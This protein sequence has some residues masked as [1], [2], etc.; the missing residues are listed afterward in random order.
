MSFQLIYHATVQETLQNGRMVSRSR[1]IPHLLEEELI[2]LSSTL[3]PGTECGTTP[4]FAY[5]IAECGGTQFHVISYLL[6]SKGGSTATYTA[7]HLALTHDEV[8]SL[9]R[10]ASRPTPAGIALALSNIGLWCTT[11]ADQRFHYIDDEP[12]L[13]A[14]ALPDAALQPTWKRLTGHKNNARAFFSAP[15]DRGCVITISEQTPASDILHLIHECDW[16]SA[17][18]GWGKSFTTHAGPNCP[19]AKYNR[20]FTTEGS[21]QA[22]HAAQM[23]EPLLPITP[24][25]EIAIPQNAPISAPLGAL[26]PLRYTPQQAPPSPAPQGYLPY[27]YTE[28]PDDAVFNILPRPNKWVRWSC[29]LGGVLILWSAVTLISGLMMDEAVELRDSIVEHVNTEEDLLFL[30]RLAAS[31]YSPDSTKRQLDRSEARLRNYPGKAHS[32]RDTLLECLTLLRSASEDT[33]GH[34]ANLRR[35]RECSS[36]L[37]LNEENMCRLYMHESTHACTAQDWAG[38]CNNEQE[39][40]EWQQ[41]LAEAPAMVEWLSEPPFFS[42]ME[43]LSVLPA[44]AETTADSPQAE[45]ETS[46]E[47]P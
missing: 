3:Y 45:T 4:Q 44:P 31:E 37:K 27:K 16:L 36:A 46:T 14:A 20:L 24:E 10:N 39:R 25:L 22:A 28:T 40:A 7:H 33:R 42:Y 11:N 5:T 17:T 35:L 18:R 12:R 1:S 13:T 43:P 34:A 19:A 9:R 23:N 2:N 26:P 29:Y 6:Q 41:L 30:S 47:E 21:E 32:Q 8:Q 38:S 15:Y